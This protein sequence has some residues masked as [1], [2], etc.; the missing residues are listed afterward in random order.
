MLLVFV[1]ALAMLAL[2]P[3]KAWAIAAIVSATILQD[4]QTVVVP[5]GGVAGYIVPWGMVILAIIVAAMIYA[6]WKGKRGE[7]P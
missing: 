4:T 7:N 2:F 3:L 1:L 6:W 5:R